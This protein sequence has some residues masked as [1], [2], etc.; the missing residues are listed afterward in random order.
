MADLIRF[1]FVLVFIALLIFL[2]GA[3]FLSLG[4]INPN[5]LLIFFTGLIFS[6][7]FQKKLK[8]GYFSVLL[9]F[10]LIIGFFVFDFWIVQWVVLMAMILAVYFSIIFLTGRPFPDFL[11]ALSAGTAVFYAVLGL[12]AHG[13]FGFYFIFWEIIYNL[14]LGAV[15]WLLLRGAEKYA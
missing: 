7:F 12:F 10:S 9:I 8:F 3:R 15:F 2:S 11:I 5:L 6:P 4:G 14:A 13:A 1:I